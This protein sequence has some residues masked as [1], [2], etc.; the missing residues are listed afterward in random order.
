MRQTHI[1][2]TAQILGR[3]PAAPALS[4]PFTNHPP[5][6]AHNGPHAEPLARVIEIGE[7]TAGIAVPERGGVRFFSSERR[8]DAIDGVVFGSVE[9]AARAAR[10]RFHAKARPSR[11]QAV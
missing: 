8:F 10:E 11:L 4:E 1:E 9:Q 2:S 6:R 3:P 7:V 5:A